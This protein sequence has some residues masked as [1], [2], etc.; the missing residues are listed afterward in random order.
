[1]PFEIPFIFVPTLEKA[2]RENL[3]KPLLSFKSRTTDH[4]NGFTCIPGS[5]M[6]TSGRQRG[7]SFN[8]PESR[9]RCEERMHITI[10]NSGGRKLASNLTS[11]KPGWRTILQRAWGQANSPCSRTRM[12][13]YAH[14]QKMYQY[15]PQSNYR[16]TSMWLSR[17][18]AP[19]LARGFLQGSAFVKVN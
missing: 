9:K 5:P 18:L 12:K 1:M 16:W 19:K 14:N 11:A 17:K 6:A 7:A 4:Q 10:V 8:L 13:K 15:F 3:M 2:K